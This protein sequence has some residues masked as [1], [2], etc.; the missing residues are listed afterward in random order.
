MTGITGGLIAYVIYA[1]FGLVGL[2][3]VV[4]ICGVLFFNH[5]E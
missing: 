1:N 2:L 4:S 3:I 5:I